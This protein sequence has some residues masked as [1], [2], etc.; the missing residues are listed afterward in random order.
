M[1]KGH[2]LFCARCKSSENLQ[3]ITSQLRRD[4]NINN[5]FRFCAECVAF[6]KGINLPQY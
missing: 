3:S 2:H 5:E 4:L 6:L 1:M